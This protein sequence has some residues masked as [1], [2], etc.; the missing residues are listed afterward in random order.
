MLA[1]EESSSPKLPNKA[2]WRK[3]CSVPR[4]TKSHSG[5]LTD[6]ISSDVTLLGPIRDVIKPEASR[7]RFLLL[8][9]L[10]FLEFQNPVKTC[11]YGR[12]CSLQC[13]RVV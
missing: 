9:K 7:G 2:T 5:L 6:N 13:L 3:L 11:D 12:C 4:D 8:W 1:D 10:E